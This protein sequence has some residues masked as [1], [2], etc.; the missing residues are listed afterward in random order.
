MILAHLWSVLEYL[1]I[2]FFRKSLTKFWTIVKQD[3]FVAVSIFL[4]FGALFWPVFTI[5]SV[6]LRSVPMIQ[7][8]SILKYPGYPQQQYQ[9]PPQ[10][11][12]PVV[13]VNQAPYPGQ[14]VVVSGNLFEWF[15]KPRLRIDNTVFVELY[16]KFTMILILVR[17]HAYP[18]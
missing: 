1:A 13:V 15:F 6:T 4:Y 9:P 11:P 7:I 18:C 12:P 3:T 16:L 10:Q 8:P 5:V 17:F 2:F 14:T